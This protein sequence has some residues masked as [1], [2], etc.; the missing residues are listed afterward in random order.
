MDLL[1]FAVMAAWDDYWRRFD[2]ID[3]LRYAWGL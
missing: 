2:Q 1:T 3:A